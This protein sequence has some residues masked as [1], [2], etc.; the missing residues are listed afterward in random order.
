MS[1]LCFGIRHSVD[2]AEIGIEVLEIACLA[3][4]GSVVGS[5]RERRDKDLPPIAFAII[6]EG[7]PQAAI[8]TDAS[9]DCHLADTEVESGFLEFLHKNV[10]DRLLECCA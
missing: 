1:D 4:H 2:G 10:D 5:E 8:G 7:L 3:D 9:S 6:D